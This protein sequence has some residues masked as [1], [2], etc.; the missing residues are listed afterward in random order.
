M[1]VIP[2]ESV[3]LLSFKDKREEIRK[4]LNEEFTSGIKEFGS[5][6]DYYDLFKTT[7]LMVSYDE[8]DNI[9]AF[10]F[11]KP[12]PVF[13]KINLLTEPF[14]NLIKLFLELDSELVI[15]DTGFNSYK[16]G[17]GIDAPYAST[18]DD[19]AAAESVIIYK[20]GYYDS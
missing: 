7:D 6:K 10:E 17:I 3:G 2:F 19:K 9:N 14:S 13:N 11:Y 12:N 5:V 1:I 16:Y 4:K 20:K 15:D 18:E 8:N